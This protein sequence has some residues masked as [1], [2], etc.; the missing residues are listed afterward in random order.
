MEDLFQ[1]IGI[2]V[3]VLLLIYI[4]LFLLNVI[5]KPKADSLIQSEAM[6]NLRPLP[7]PTK[8]KSYLGRV[9]AWIFNIRRWELTRN[10]Y[11]QF[12]DD[13][14]DD[15]RIVLHQGF[16][17]DGASIPRPLW[18]LL[19]P[20]GLLLLPGLLL[21]YGYKYVYRDRCPDLGLN[22]ILRRATK[23]P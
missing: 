5:L 9:L 3:A 13:D 8:N 7:I 20:V 12:K 14:G 1:W 23:K 15:L 18:A 11:F 17:F 21:D 16:I 2:I 6:P 19:S 22:C 4:F 10:W